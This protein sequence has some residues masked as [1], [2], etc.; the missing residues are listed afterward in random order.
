MRGEDEPHAAAAAYE[1]LL[2]AELG[3]LPRLDLIQLGMGPDGHT[4]SLFPGTLGTIDE[5]KRC[6]ANFVPKFD[7]WRLTLT[8]RTIN[9][10]REVIIT[11]G[12][13]EKADAL[14]AVL[15]GPSQPDL[16]P[17]QIVHPTD[18]ELH[19]LVDAAAAWKL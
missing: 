7:R 1:A 15:D 17:S 16:Y 11:A 12:G 2:Q 5:A 10:A 4:A 14:H 8:P 3:D 13:A 18:G 9:A 6:V 19:W